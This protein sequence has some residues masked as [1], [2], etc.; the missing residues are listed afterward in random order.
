ME[1]T[2]Q[3]NVGL[4][5]GFVNNRVTGSIELYKANTTDL[6]LN[7]TL[8]AVS[9]FV[10][11]VENIGK[12]MNQGIEINLNTVNVKT[13]D[14]QWS[15]TI[16]WSA[17]REEIV[18]LLNK[19]ADGKP[20]DMLANRWFIGQ[21][22]Q[23]YYNNQ[24]DGIWQNTDED[25]AEMAKFNANGHKFYPGTIKVVD[26][27]TVDSDG[28]GINDKGDY[29]IT[30]DDMGILGTN[31]PKWT[32]GITNTLTYKN[33]D[34]SFFVYARI[35]QKYFGGYPNSYGGIWPNGRVENDIWSWDN[36]NG[37]WPMPNSGS[38]ENFN[39][40]MLYHDGSYIA[41]RNI[42]LTYTFPSNLLKPVNMSRLSVFGQVINPFM[43][44]GDI[45]QMGLN[46]EDN[47][48]W[49]VASSNGSPLGGMNNNTILPQSF[50]FGIRA[51]F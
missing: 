46:P 3:Y 50:V 16:N 47:T 35:G 51:S 10:S 48:N 32:A 33:I 12:T 36:P 43:F 14:F 41:V 7:K 19:D 42:S 17:N 27:P 23:V 28:D 5:F 6:L 37:R 26:Q 20:L 13:K 8:P 45:V 9:G 39:T 15:T 1:K 2:A 40:A 38:V 34:L 30:G 25:K 11:K 29:K 18:E 4:D 49:D 22:I 31:R 44:G 24:N 21:P